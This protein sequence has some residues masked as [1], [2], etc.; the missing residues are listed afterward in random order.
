MIR[1][2]NI[3]TEKDIQIEQLVDTKPMFRPVITGLFAAIRTG[4]WKKIGHIQVNDFEY[5]N[6]IATNYNQK[7]GKASIWFLWNGEKYIRL[8]T[9]LP[10]KYK[11]LE[12]LMVWSPYDVVDRIET[13]KYPFPYRDLIEHNEFSPRK[14][15]G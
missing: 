6:F 15:S 1:I 7:T 3:I 12:Y 4:L 9:E 13:G 11:E 2:F 10:E 8:G 5:P 14:L